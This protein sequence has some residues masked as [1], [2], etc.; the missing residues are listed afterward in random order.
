MKTGY[1]EIGNRQ[2]MTQ[3]K[4]QHSIRTLPKTGILENAE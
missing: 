1:E 4:E 2:E 3:R